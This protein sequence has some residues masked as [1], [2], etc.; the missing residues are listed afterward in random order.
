MFVSRRAL[1]ISA[2]P[3]AL[4]LRG[5]HAADSP[6]AVIQRFYDAL[7]AEMKDAKHL[8][9]DQRFQRLAPAISQTYNL[10]LMSRLSVGPG[11]NQLQPAQQQRFSEDFARYTISV[12]ANRFDGYNG[13]RFEVSPNPVANPNGVIVETKLIKS[14]NDKVTLNY[15]LR[16][17]GGGPWQVIDIYLSGTISELATRRSEFAGVLQ[18]SG[19]EALI[20]LIE[21][22][23]A[24]QRAG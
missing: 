17:E 13:E 18:Q 4:W 1:L 2:A 15:L 23:T 11:W 12:Y 16:Q 10:P 8:S 22:R 3:A 7:L 6:V 5:A 21:D 19:G 24:A 9:F 14:D 20:K